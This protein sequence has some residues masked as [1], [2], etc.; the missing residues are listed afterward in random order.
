MKKNL[1]AFTLVFVFLLSACAPS[2]SVPAKQPLSDGTVNLAAQ[3]VYPKSIGFDDYE[4]SFALREQYPVDAALWDSMADFSARSAA[5]ALGGTEKNALY[6][7][8]SLWFALA[9]CAE[10][11]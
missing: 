2:A 9:L 10:S 5:L 11:A 4:G 7:P 3:P 1:L 8:I 6:S